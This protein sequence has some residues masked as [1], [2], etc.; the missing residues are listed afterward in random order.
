MTTGFVDGARLMAGALGMAEYPFAVIEHPIASAP[1][2][3]LAERALATV[4]QA[5]RILGIS[6]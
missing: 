1:D 4:L 3:A 5:E 2:D 6:A